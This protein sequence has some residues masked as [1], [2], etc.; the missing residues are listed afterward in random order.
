M[1]GLVRLFAPALAVALA[2]CVGNEGSAPWAGQPATLA[3]AD[4][5]GSQDEGG[6]PA[7]ETPEPLD[8]G[9]AAAGGEDSGSGMPLGLGVTRR[10]DP[11]EAAYDRPRA[12]HPAALA[13]PGHDV[14]V[15]EA[16]CD[17]TAGSIVYM[18]KRQ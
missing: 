4:A 17:K 5:E 15:C 7:E 13:H 12:P 6:A 8:E 9:Q 10:M 11:F 2:V 1:R 14:V 18:K 16:G 3:E